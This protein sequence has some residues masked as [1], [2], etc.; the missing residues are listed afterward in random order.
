MQRG[1]SLSPEAGMPQRARLFWK[2]S[3]AHVQVSP[4]QSYAEGLMLETR[5]SQASRLPME[6]KIH[7]QK[8]TQI[9]VGKKAFFADYRGR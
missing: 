7:L 5:L 3:I 1:F 6:R 8:T 4:T 2:R 9:V